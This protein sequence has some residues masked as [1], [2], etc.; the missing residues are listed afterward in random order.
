MTGKYTV[1]RRVGASFGP[2]MLQAGAVKGLRFPVVNLEAVH[3]NSEF[4]PPLSPPS[5]WLLSGDSFVENV[6]LLSV[7][8]NVKRWDCLRC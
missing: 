2:E 5:A 7:R 8:S 3:C 1:C 6:I 4:L